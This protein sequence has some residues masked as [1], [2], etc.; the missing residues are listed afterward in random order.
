MTEGLVLVRGEMRVD[1]WGPFSFSLMGKNSQERKRIADFVKPFYKLMETDSPDYRGLQQVDFHAGLYLTVNGRKPEVLVSIMPPHTSLEG[2]CLIPENP[3][4]ISIK[5]RFYCQYCGPLSLTLFGNNDAEQKKIVSWLRSY[6][7]PKHQPRYFRIQD[8]FARGCL[9]IWFS[10]KDQT[11]ADIKV[12]V[13][14]SLQF[15]KSVKQI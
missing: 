4:S 6:L 8:L 3:K 2:T 11:E 10:N 1:Q 7:E 15:I 5:G 13:F 9:T 14:P 12:T